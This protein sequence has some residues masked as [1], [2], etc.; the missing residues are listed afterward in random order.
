M[1]LIVQR[2]PPSLA[3]TPK[4]CFLV[5]EPLDADTEYVPRFCFEAKIDFADVRSGLRETCGVCSAVD[6]TP[7]DEEILWTE[8]MVWSIDPARIQSDPP[9]QGRV[10]ALPE[11][12]DVHA[13][14]Q[15]ETH[16]VRYLLRYFKLRIYRNFAL[17]VYSNSTEKLPDFTARCRDLLGESFRHDLDALHDVFDRNHEQIKG[18]YLGTTE[19]EGS[20]SSSPS[21]QL[22]SIL[23]R[24]SERI[25]QMFLR[26]ELDLGPPLPAPSCGC[27]TGLEMEER[28]CSLEADAYRAI[29]RLLATWQDKAYNIDEYVVHPS[30][31]DVHLS[32]TRI[33]WMPRGDVR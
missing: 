6:L 19:W 33:L 28:L 1:S 29:G 26:A 14:A 16:F 3:Q 5:A 10:S 18:K 22:K 25:A 11:F 31:K 13:V 8:D 30:L 4:H 15:A 21:S 23:H 20:D 27:S 9:P 24:S 7:L 12:I 32:R 17:N 2:H